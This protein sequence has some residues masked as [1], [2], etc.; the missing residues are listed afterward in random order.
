MIIKKNK[1][2]K[3]DHN[4]LWKEMLYVIRLKIKQGSSIIYALC[5]KPGNTFK[6][7][8]EW[9]YWRKSNLQLQ[10][11]ETISLVLTSSIKFSEWK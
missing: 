9:K 5:S 10:L 6:K 11:L 8:I 1:R 2:E 4:V 3:N 7:H